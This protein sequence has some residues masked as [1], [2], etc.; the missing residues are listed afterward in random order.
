[1]RNKQILNTL[2]FLKEDIEERNAAEEERQN[3]ETVNYSNYVL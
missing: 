3:N 1:M 2:T